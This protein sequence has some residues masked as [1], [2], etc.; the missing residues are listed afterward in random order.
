MWT[1]HC[2]DGGIAF[3][4]VA[5]LAPSPTS[6]SASQRACHFARDR[7][8]IARLSCYVIDALAQTPPGPARVIGAFGCPTHRT[9]FIVG[10]ITLTNGGV[11]TP[12]LARCHNTRYHWCMYTRRNNGSSEA[13]NRLAQGY[14]C[15]RCGASV[16]TECNTKSGKPHLRR[17]D[18]AAARYLAQK[19]A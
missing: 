17:V 5:W 12:N 7:R 6:P 16:D 13:L 15:P 4:P 18:K 11:S 3:S 14:D 2:G 9:T 1:L 8:E 10:V 19:E